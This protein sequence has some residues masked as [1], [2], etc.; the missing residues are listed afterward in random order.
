MKRAF[1]IVSLAAMAT[2]CFGGEKAIPPKTALFVTNDCGPVSAV[3]RDFY[4]FT[5][6]D[7]AKRLKLKGEDAPWRP[8]CDWKGLGFN[9]VE[10]SGPEGVAAT[11]GMTEVTFTRPKYDKDGALVRTS[12]KTGADPEVRKLCRVVRTGEA[13]SVESCGPDPKDVNPRQVGPRPEDATP[14]NSRIAPPVDG[15]APTAR[16]VGTFQPDPGATRQ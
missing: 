11:P 10:V 13:W 8:T 4:K 2:A 6:T 7:A 5:A 12:L 16:D 9:V 14:E 15:A 3:G 1:V